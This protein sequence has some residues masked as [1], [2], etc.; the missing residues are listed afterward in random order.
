MI[1]Q[2]EDP[3]SNT[4]QA[5]HT[6]ARS[7]GRV[8]KTLGLTGI[9]I[10]AMALIAPGAF[11]WVLYQAQAAGSAGPVG[12]IWPGV[13]TALIIAILTAFSLGELARRYPDAGLR[14]AYHFADHVFR[15]KSQ[16]NTGQRM[17]L[18]KWITG[19]SAHLYYW[20]YPGVMVAF[21]GFLIDYVLR[22]IGYHPTAFGQLIL[23]F[24]FSAFIGFL[25]LRG[26]TGSPTSSVILNVVQIAILLIFSIAAIVFR[27][28]NP[29]Q[30]PASGWVHLDVLSVLLPHSLSGLIFQAA[31]A[32]I[33][34]MGFEA[35]TALGATATN[36][37]R[38]IPR[39]GVLALVIQGAAAYLLE[40]FAVGLALNAIL[41]PDG[42]SASAVHRASML[43]GDLS[44]QIGD[45]LMGGN[46]LAVLIAIA[47]TVFVALLGAG[48]TSLNSGVRISFSMA[49]DKEMPS[50]LSFLH[51]RYATPYV[52]VLLLSG[53]SAV[54]GSAGV[55]G[56]I[57]V[58]MGIILACNLGAFILYGLLCLLTITAFTNKPEFNLFK[59][60]ILP[61]IGLVINLGIAI[62]FPVVGL[63]SGGTVALAS[64]I[65][66]GIAAF[67]LIVSGAYYLLRSR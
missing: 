47:F 56:G 44:L 64:A 63:R 21:T 36:P 31:L 22:Q 48:L 67:W 65:A 62:A 12:D 8:R 9:T 54:I 40:Y 30:I 55:L 41:T 51:P 38:D 37:G 17:R 66:L 34:M 39:A 32:M 46:G 28:L 59:H 16:E 26:I 20:I 14:G 10:N 60:Q 27:I 5:P 53:V 42:L 1:Q 6:S 35:S 25:A 4:G 61:G 15:E 49:L 3:I 23:T 50:V 29:L 43:T 13:M 11:M 19:W 57:P 45:S 18:L 7:T 58:L 52:T 24:S 33:L 2:N